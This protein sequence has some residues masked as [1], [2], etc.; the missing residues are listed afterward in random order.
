MTITVQNPYTV[1]VYVIYV[2]RSDNQVVPQKAFV[3]SN[4]GEDPLDEIKIFSRARFTGTF[5]FKA[6]LF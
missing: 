5:F 6:G 3:K 4:T 1:T 2:V